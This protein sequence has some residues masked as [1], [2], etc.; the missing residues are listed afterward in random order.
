MRLREGGAGFDWAAFGSTLA[1]LDWAWLSLSIVFAY[2]SYYGRA[3]R[4]AVFL[5]PLRPQARMW[6]LV[7]ATTIGF[8]AIVLLGRPGEFVRPYLIA[9]K[10]KVPVSSQL[11][12]WV[13]E[14]I[15]D[16]LF[17][18][19]IFGYGLSRVRS[20]NAQV[21]EAL[22][23]VLQVGGAAVWGMS[24]ICLILLFL[25]RQYPD[26]FR[27]RLTD[28]LQFLPQSQ[29]ER[30]EKWLHSFLQGVESLRSSRA[31]LAAVGLTALEW[32]L[33][34]A[35]Y[36]C[37]MKSFHGTFEFGLLDILI[38]MGF[39]AFGAVVQLPGI[40][41]GMQ[42]VSVLVL[43]EIFQLPIAIATS[44]TLT[45]WFITFVI[46]VPVGLLMAF[47]EGLNWRKLKHLQEESEA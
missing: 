32:V 29:L 22:R 10:E 24:C 15:F 8:T 2:A 33:I 47:Q 3:V 41:G 16:L 40:G 34:G 18:L 25:L 26:V 36:Y 28:A 21:G 4:W 5:R 14:R 20:S 19:L 13:L 7:T 45:L 1:N 31:L 39:V 44:A 12:V 6:N 38:Y 30:L 35:C 11:A 23:W 37:V 43:H 46:V 42:V 17:A 9:W 27:R